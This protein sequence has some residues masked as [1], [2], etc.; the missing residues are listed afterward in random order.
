MSEFFSGVTF[1]QQRVTPA[2]TAVFQ[3]AVLSD[4]IITG[5]GLS[6]SGYTLTM[7]PGELVACGRAFKHVSSQ[8]WPVVDS[9]SGFARLVLTIDLTRTASKVIFDQV[10][11][12]LEYASSIDGFPD[13]EQSDVN[14]AG[15]RYQVVACVVSLGVGGITGIVSSLSR[16]KVL[17]S[18]EGAGALTEL[19]SAGYMVLSDKQIVESIEAIPADAPEGA[20]F[21]IPIG[22]AE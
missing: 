14:A 13:L 22:E 18:P 9:T 10:V 7:A 19:L 5:C 1:S 17:G 8:N 21:V 12:S 20:F 3:R 4:G 11:D 6:Y 15:T 2:D 16:A